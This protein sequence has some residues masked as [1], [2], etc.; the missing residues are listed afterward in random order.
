MASVLLMTKSYF[1]QKDALKVV[2]SVLQSWQDD[3][4]VSAISHWENEEASPPIYGLAAY[5]I[6]RG[7]ITKKDGTYY[8]KVLATLIFAENARFPS[9]KQWTFILKKTRYGW[10]I[11]DFIL[12]ED[13][14]AP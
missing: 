3:D 8:A 2:R 11:T 6:S 14:A 7:T 10:K 1:L 9:S 4:L 5:D 13:P 12:S